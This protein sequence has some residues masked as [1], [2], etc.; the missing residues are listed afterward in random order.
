MAKPLINSDIFSNVADK[1]QY[2]L[3]MLGYVLII[4]FYLY[5]LNLEGINEFILFIKISRLQ[6]LKRKKQKRYLL[7]H[8]KE[9]KCQISLCSETFT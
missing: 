4:L 8:E 1:K 6:T 3:Q 7:I 2:C 9:K 5:F